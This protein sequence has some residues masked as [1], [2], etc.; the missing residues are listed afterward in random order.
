MVPFLW[1]LLFLPQS[2]SSTLQ[3]LT[4]GIADSGRVL[5]LSMSPSERLTPKSLIAP[6]APPLL[7]FR[8]FE[9][10]SRHR[11]GKLDLMVDDAGH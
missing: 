1:I 7:S 4:K 6:G 11:Y 2:E 8:L 9:A 3:A 5:E 10:K